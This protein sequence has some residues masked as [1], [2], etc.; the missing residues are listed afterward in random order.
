MAHESHPDAATWNVLA[1]QRSVQVLN[2][3]YSKALV[4]PELSKRVNGRVVEGRVQEQRYD[5][6]FRQT[7]IGMKE[8]L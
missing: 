4:T 6:L 8:M 2:Q 5:G 7:A 3:G 1:A